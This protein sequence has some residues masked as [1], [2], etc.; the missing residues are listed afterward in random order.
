[1][2]KSVSVNKVHILK[3][4]GLLTLA[5]FTLAFFAFPM[6]SFARPQMIIVTFDKSKDKAFLIS[7]DGTSKPDDK[8]DPKTSTPPK[9]GVELVQVTPSGPA[10]TSDGS[11]PTPLT[12]TAPTLGI[13]LGNGKVEIPQP[14]TG[15]TPLKGV[16]GKIQ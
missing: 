15:T 11:T 6:V 7:R 8:F 3:F 10:P 13:F 1:M 5:A 16:Q 2:V 14:G 9:D 4:A 12:S